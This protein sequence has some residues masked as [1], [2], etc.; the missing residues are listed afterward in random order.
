MVWWVVHNG[1]YT[2]TPNSNMAVMKLIK[3]FVL[4]KYAGQGK[5][6]NHGYKRL[7]GQQTH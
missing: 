2:K 6:Y 3:M 4:G 1:K 5:I 7:L